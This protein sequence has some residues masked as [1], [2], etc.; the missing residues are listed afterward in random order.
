MFDEYL[1]DLDEDQ[2]AALEAIVA[3]VADVVPDA[4]EGTS[5]GMPAFR[6]AGKPLLGFAAHKDHLGLYP[7]SPEVLE[8]VAVYLEGFGR[9]KGSIRFTAQQPIPPEVLTALVQGRIAEIDGTT[10]TD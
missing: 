1:A 10:P 8:R 9:S 4:E 7:F 2:R 3:H 6:Y 5:Y